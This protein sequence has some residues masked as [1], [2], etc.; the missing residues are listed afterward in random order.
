MD[1]DELKSFLRVTE[2]DDDV[3]IE[4]LQV[5]AEEYLT[6][7][8]IKKNYDKELYAL[9]IKLLVSH[10]F[11]NRMIQSDKSQNKLSFSLDAIIMQLKYSPD[12]DE[13]EDDE[14]VQT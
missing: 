14:E 13:D 8:G 11:E 9:A 7:A 10:W 6:N 5:T 3:F 4:S 2:N 12:N 1:L